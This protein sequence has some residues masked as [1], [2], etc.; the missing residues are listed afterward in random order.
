MGSNPIWHSNQART[1]VRSYDPTVK[2][3]S[4]CRV[5]KSIDQ[6]AFRNKTTGT[7]NSLCKPCHQ[8]YTN[9]HYARNRR[10][11]ITQIAASNDKRREFYNQRIRAIKQASGCVDCGERDPVV[12]D[13]DHLRDKEFDIS[14]SPARYSWDRIEAEIQKCEVVCANCHRRRT[15]TRRCGVNGSTRPL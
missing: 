4:A 3:C 2:Q 13:F 1:Y 15:H 11:R 6:F 7:R 5:M 9:D 12:L 14:Q 8:Q 10:R